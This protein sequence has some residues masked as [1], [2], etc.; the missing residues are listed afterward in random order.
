MSRLRIEARHARTRF[1]QARLVGPPATGMDARKTFG[2]GG[3]I[4]MGLFIRIAA[5]ATS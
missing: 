3:R 4:G 2:H 1:A 5:E